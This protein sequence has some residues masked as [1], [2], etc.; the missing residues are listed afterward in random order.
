MLLV[1]WP[2]LSHSLLHQ[3]VAVIPLGTLG[4]APLE[5][6]DSGNFVFGIM[7]L[8]RVAKA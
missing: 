4:L 2:P 7:A 3:A 8:H 5:A 6:E 1:A